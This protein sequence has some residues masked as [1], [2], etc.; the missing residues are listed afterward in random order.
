MAQLSSSLQRFAR[1]ESASLS[2]ELILILPL[3]LWGFMSIYAIFDLY[4]ARNL[5]LKGNYAV[6]DLLSRETNPIDMTY[7]NG[8]AAVFRYLTQGDDDTWLRVTEVY[9]ESYC[10]DNDRR[11]LRADW[12]QATGGREAYDD[13][14]VNVGLRSRMPLLASGARAL[15]VETSV[16]YYVPFVP[17]VIKV[18]PIPGYESG[19]G[20]VRNN[21]FV[22]T[23][24]TE[25]RFAPTLCWRGLSEC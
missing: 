6:S 1:D 21:T 18:S 16:N 3:L 23:V 8:I 14:D 7:L 13:T 15:V 22:D 10:S 25:P 19:W 5:A 20:I 24:V 17:P 4:R 2:V 11:V 12:S 9:C